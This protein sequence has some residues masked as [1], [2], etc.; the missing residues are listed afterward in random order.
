MMVD[1]T[2]GQTYNHWLKYTTGFYFQ[3]RD[4]DDTFSVYGT[5]EE[6]IEGLHNIPKWDEDYERYDYHDALDVTESQLNVFVLTYC[7]AG[8]IH[9]NWWNFGFDFPNMPA[10]ALKLYMTPPL[11]STMWGQPVWMNVSVSM[12]NP[13]TEGGTATYFYVTV[14]SRNAPDGYITYDYLQTLDSRVNPNT[15]ITNIQF[16]PSNQQETT[17]WQF[18]PDPICAEEVTD[19]AANTLKSSWF[20]MDME[21]TRSGQYLVKLKRD[22]I[23]DNY[24]NIL[25]SPMLIHRAMSGDINNPLLYNSEGFNFNQIKKN[26]ILLKDKFGTP[27]YVLYFLKDAGDKS[28]SDLSV[29]AANYDY[30]ISQSIDQSIFGTGNKYHIAD[31][32]DFMV[33]YRVEAGG[34]AWAFFSDRYTLHVKKSALDFTSDGRSSETEVIWFVWD[35]AHVKPALQGKFQGQYTVIKDKFCA[36]FEAFSGNSTNVSS[37]VRADAIVYPLKLFGENPVL[38]A[39]YSGLLGLRDVM[40]HSMTTCTPINYFATYGIIY[41]VITVW[42]F[43]NLARL[44]SQQKRT[45]LWVFIMLL[46]ML[47][48]ED[49]NGNV[50]LNIFMLYGV[51]NKLS[52]KRK[53]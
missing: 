51:S 3:Q 30:S 34:W 16:D 9:D 17:D 2:A 18:S 41:G 40:G 15:V 38:G 20:V 49:F 43:Y 23:A 22:I 27:W 19:Y 31:N 4:G 36:F 46:V 1:L 33:E 45:C 10:R 26:E 6:V 53:I 47:A 32:M 42:L 21:R 48:T 50:C 14:D 11:S 25:D 28:V 29:T 35:Q 8:E 37:Q 44:F 12:T 39:G 24:N 7:L 52:S 5:N 13:A